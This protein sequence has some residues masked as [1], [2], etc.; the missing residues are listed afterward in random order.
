ML[1]SKSVI[2]CSGRIEVHNILHMERFVI[3]LLIL[4][5]IRG[6]DVWLDT[7]HDLLKING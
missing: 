4:R 2:V 5:S 3:K 7:T 6:H 1:G